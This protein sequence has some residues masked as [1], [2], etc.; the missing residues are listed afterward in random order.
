M[1][2]PGQDIEFA[3]WQHPNTGYD[4]FTKN[5]LRGAAAG[6]GVAY[7]SLASDLSGVNF[8]AG[9]IGE[10]SMQRTWLII[11]KMIVDRIHIPLFERWIAEAVLMGDSGVPFMPLDQMQAVRFV[12][13]G[14]PPIQPREAAAANES[15]IKNRLKSRS[16]IIREQGGDPVDVF[17]EL[18]GEEEL[19]KELGLQS[20]A[21]DPADMPDKGDGDG[22][23]DPD[24]NS[25]EDAEGNNKGTKKLTTP[26]IREQ[27]RAER[28]AGASYS[29]LARKHGVGRTTVTKMLLGLTWK[30]R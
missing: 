9:R 23:E 2:D 22:D 11:R 28:A 13:P 24:D 7:H 3:N 10:M 30:R 17:E 20:A 25:G 19:L 29:E 1:L 5:Q 21:P 6:L 16:E 18:A 8:S 15:A 4:P 12:G 26:E 27:I 14:F